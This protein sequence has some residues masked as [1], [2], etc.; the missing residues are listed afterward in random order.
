M[1]SKL[2][3]CFLFCSILIHLNAQEQLLG[4][5]DLLASISETYKTTIKDF[6]AQVTWT[7]EKDVQTGTLWFKNPQKLRIDFIV[8]L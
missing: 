4:A 3:F 1:K 2:F 5:K 7:Q 6:E 8:V